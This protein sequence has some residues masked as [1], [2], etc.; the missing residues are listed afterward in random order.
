MKISVFNFLLHGNVNF[1]I[2]FEQID[3]IPEI[4][5]VW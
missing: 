5:L 4:F 3:N 1:V 2:I